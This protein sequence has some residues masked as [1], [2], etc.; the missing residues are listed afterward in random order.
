MSHFQGHQEF[1]DK[2]I[3]LSEQEQK[4]PTSV[5]DAFFTDYKLSEI[6][7]LNHDMDEICLT[8]DKAPFD[9]P[10]QRDFLIAYRWSEE[11]VLEAAWVLLRNKPLEKRPVA[12][13]D[14]NWN[15]IV[16]IAKILNLDDLQRKVSEIELEMINFVM[17]IVN[18]SNELLQFDS[19]RIE[20]SIRK[21]KIY[22]PSSTMASK[23]ISDNQQEPYAILDLHDLSQRSLELQHKITKLSGTIIRACS[24]RLK[25]KFP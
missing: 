18:A 1:Y 8:T 10:I 13:E 3:Y 9:D 2:A 12:A 16:N 4:D 7:Q 20:A 6:R 14:P 25:L 17:I 23:D 15:R 24:E 5:I 22:P 21:L 19:K 11:K